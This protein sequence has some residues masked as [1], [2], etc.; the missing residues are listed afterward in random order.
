[1]VDREIAAGTY[2]AAWNGKTVSGSPVPAGAYYLRLQA[3][4]IADRAQVTVVR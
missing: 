1:M 4:G 3:P 2:V